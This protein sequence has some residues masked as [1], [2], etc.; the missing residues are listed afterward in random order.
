MK[1]KTIA[2]VASHMAADTTRLQSM[3]EKDNDVIIVD[4]NT[5][6]E[7]LKNQFGPA[8]I[9]YKMNPAL[10]TIPENRFICKGKHQYREVKQQDGS[11]IKVRWICQCGRE[12]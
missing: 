10:L 7:E 1:N 6:A 9:P 3:L 4:A 5:K 2:I 8:P 12:L 11:Q